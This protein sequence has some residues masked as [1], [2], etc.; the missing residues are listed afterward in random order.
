MNVCKKLE[1]NFDECSY[2]T[3]QLKRFNH[4]IK[5]V[6]GEKKFSCE[7]ENCQ[8]K[9]ANVSHYNRHLKIHTGE[10]KHICDKC[11]YTCIEK[12]TLTVH[13]RMHTGV[14]DYKCD[15]CDYA[16][17]SS[18]ALISHKK[19]NHIKTKEFECEY[20][21]CSYKCITSSSMK[22]HEKTHTGQKDYICD[23]ENCNYTCTN[24]ANLKRHQMTHSKIKKYKCDLCNYSCKTQGD[25]KNHSIVH[26]NEK[27]ICCEYPDCSYKCKRKADLNRHIRSHDNIRNYCCDYEG[28]NMKF[29]S[30]SNLCEHKVTHQKNRSRIKCIFKGCSSDFN[31]KSSLKD[32]L[33]RHYNIRN[34]KCTQIDCNLLF[35]TNNEL[36]KHIRCWHTIDGQNRKKK[37]EHRVRQLLKK[38][39]EI[40]EEIV[41]KYKD[42][43]V[44][45]PDKYCARIDFNIINITSLCVIIEVDELQHVSYELRCE[46][47]RMCQ[48]H[49][50][51]MKG[52][53]TRPI[54]FV[55]YNPNGKFYHDD[56]EINMNRTE[57]ETILMN[58]LAK[59]ASGKI[60]YTEPLN[61]KYICYNTN[62]NKMPVICDD[63]DFSEEMKACIRI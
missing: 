24:N 21:N 16:C 36:Q 6:H 26:I 40:D 35:Y 57:R 1:C 14:K 27:T 54:L 61:I 32:H 52:G 39:Y 46:Q 18:S 63:P 58:Y 50:S 37:Q 48:I 51:I 31:R 9:T 3:D 60:T 41:L 4:H 17:S 55:R 20:D 12:D 25:L 53:D 2:Q 49:E 30:S 62:Q 5:H 13:Y 8:Y 15:L 44:Y 28:C 56:V 47:S 59:L 23:I 45:D 7:H 11:G 42:G 19:Y 10:K 38:N 43:C 22:L 34:F 33:N 29:K